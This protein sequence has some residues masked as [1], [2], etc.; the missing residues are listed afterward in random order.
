MKMNTNRGDEMKRLPKEFSRY[1]SW[2]S[3]AE[4][5]RECRIRTLSHYVVPTVTWRDLVPYKCWMVVLGEA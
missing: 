1:G 2:S 5:Q 4:A 3:K